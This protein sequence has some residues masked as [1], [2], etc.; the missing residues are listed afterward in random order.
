[1]PSADHVLR[2]R[3]Q[4][5]AELLDR[6]SRKFYAQ[7][8]KTLNIYRKQTVSMRP[9]VPPGLRL[10]AYR[11]TSDTVREQL[12]GPVPEGGGADHPNNT[13]QSVLNFGNHVCG[14]QQDITI[15]SEIVKQLD[16]RLQ[17]DT[18]MRGKPLI[19]IPQA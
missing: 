5:I 15:Q 7:K 9:I 2:S 18:V 17:N 3:P 4:Y 13:H 6:A 19:N 10:Q 8:L 11:R 14:A 1:M 12:P 16:K